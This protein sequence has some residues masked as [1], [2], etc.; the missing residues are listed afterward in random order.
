[1]ASPT[2]V[3]LTGSKEA[4]LTRP[5]TG[6]TAGRP[7]MPPSHAG[8]VHFPCHARFVGG[9]DDARADGDAPFAEVAVSHALAVLAEEGEFA[10][11]DGTG[12]A[13]RLC[14]VA[15]VR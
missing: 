7:A 11:D 10:L 5:R 1:M 14:L 3:A 8:E 6:S 12:G 15:E 2:K 13:V 4:D 9:L